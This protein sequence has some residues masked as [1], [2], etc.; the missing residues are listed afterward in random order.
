MSGN[1]P[2]FVS[3]SALQSFLVCKKRY[4]LRYLQQVQW[5]AEQFAPLV[6]S[7]KRIKAGEFFHKLAHQYFLGLPA[8][9]LEAQARQYGHP[10]MLVWW[11]N[12]LR[13]ITNG[14]INISTLTHRSAEK[15]AF[16]Q[17]G[18]Y[19]LA[20][21]F[22]LIGFSSTGIHI[23]DWKTNQTKP[24]TAKLEADLQSLVYLLVAHLS[25]LVPLDLRHGNNITMAYWFANHPQQPVEIH[26]NAHK[27]AEAE[28]TILEILKRIEA[29]TEFAEV[30]DLRVCTGCVFRSYCGRG[31]A[32]PEYDED[33]F[34]I[35]PPDEFDLAWLLANGQDF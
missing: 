19:T 2:V 20:A 33:G 5:P 31:V 16:G 6:E 3:Q 23:F 30:E 28:K 9:I 7:E 12:F 8:E 14:V 29:E 24:P 34:A 18:G 27:L 25:P 32:A 21:K 13:S 4:Q 1:L 35:D 10:Q 15:N 22:D 17:L 11:Q 26:A